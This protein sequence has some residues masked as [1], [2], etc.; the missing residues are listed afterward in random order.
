MVARSKWRDCCISKISSRKLVT[1]K[2]RSSLSDDEL[3][4][5][6]DPEACAYP[7]WIKLCKRDPEARYAKLWNPSPT[8]LKM[9]FPTWQWEGDFACACLR[10]LTVDGPSVCWILDLSQYECPLLTTDYAPLAVECRNSKQTQM[11]QMFYLISLE[12][13]RS[14]N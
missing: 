7:T 9:Q 2:F 14:T 3:Y 5:V 6:E 1:T 13:I 11:E 12:V 4:K 8:C 10:L